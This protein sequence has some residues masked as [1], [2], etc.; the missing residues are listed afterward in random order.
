MSF[1]FHVE[2]LGTLVT[3]LSKPYL[4]H[5]SVVVGYNKEQLFFQGCHSYG[6]DGQVLQNSSQEV[7]LGNANTQHHVKDDFE[8]RDLR[9][10]K[11]CRIL[12][13]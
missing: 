2:F 1:N 12:K 4:I 3:P 6:V 10:R 9:N 11:Q 13:N 5:L 8:A 7:T